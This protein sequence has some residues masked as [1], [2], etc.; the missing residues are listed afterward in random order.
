MGIGADGQTSRPILPRQINYFA[1]TY[2]SGSA[3]LTDGDAL[4]ITKKLV[5]DR[6]RQRLHNNAR[7][8]GAASVIS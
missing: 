2:F 4:R 3:L 8:A 5:N 7:V 1:Q 6:G